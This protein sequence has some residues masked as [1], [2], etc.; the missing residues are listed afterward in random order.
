MKTK[1]AEAIQL[2]EKETGGTAYSAGVEITEGKGSIQVNLFTNEKFTIVNVD[3]ETK[4]V[5]V[6]AK[7]TE[8][9][10]AGMGGD[11]RDE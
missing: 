4:K 11:A 6:S 10:N 8:E 1:L 9:E 2:A 7:K 5:T 3:P